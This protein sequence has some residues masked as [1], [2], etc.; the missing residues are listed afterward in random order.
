M[1]LEMSGDLLRHFASWLAVG[2]LLEAVWGPGRW[3]MPALMLAIFCARIGTAD[4]E[5]SRAEIIGGLAAAAVWVVWLHAERHRWPVVAVAL[6]AAILVEAL[7]PF[8]FLAVARPFDWVPFW[9]LIEG[10]IWTAVPSLMSK[11]FL[12]GALV[13]SLTRSG[14]RWTTATVGAAAFVFLVH[15]LQVFLPGRS[16]EITDC[17]LVLVAGGMMRALD[18]Q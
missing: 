4:I 12:Y 13:W 9:G 7:Q 3:R 18:H 5:L 16:A 11:F 14:L 8:Q 10:S 2:A 6:A 17:L 1:L 15:Y